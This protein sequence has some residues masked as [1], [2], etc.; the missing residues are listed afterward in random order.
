M[1]FFLLTKANFYMLISQTSPYGCLLLILLFSAVQLLAGFSLSFADLKKEK[2]LKV[3]C[4]FL[5]KNK[6]DEIERKTTSQFESLNGRKFCVR[7]REKPFGV[8]NFEG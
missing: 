1:P 4:I 8:E 6:K 3:N 7:G 2:N 5:T